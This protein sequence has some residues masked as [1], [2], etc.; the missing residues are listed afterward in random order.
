MYI[1]IF[2]S[3][4]VHYEQGINLF[5]NLE[6]LKCQKKLRNMDSSKSFNNVILP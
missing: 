4:D 3:S 2:L 1:V 6:L 5:I